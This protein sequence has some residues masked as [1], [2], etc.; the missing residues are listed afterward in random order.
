M[1]LRGAAFASPTNGVNVDNWLSTIKQQVVAQARAASSGQS[2]WLAAFTSPMTITGS[3]D[4]FDEYTSEALFNGQVTLEFST[5]GKILV[6]GQLN[7]AANNISIS[8]RL[9]ADLSKIS[10][11]AAT[12]LF[13][14]DVPD[15]VRVL[16][17]Y[18]KLQMGFKNAQGD[19]VAFTV[20]S[21]SPTSPTATLEGPGN[22]GTVAAG[23]LNGRGFVDVSY[24]VPSGD[25]LDASSITD[26][27]PEFTVT[28]TTG[29]IQ[30]DSTQAPILVNATT[31][32]YRY[33]TVSSN[34]GRDDHADP[35]RQRLGASSR[36]RAATR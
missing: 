12:V 1:Q 11:G 2:S 25:R 15:Q 20:P 36:P 24:A 7:F 8:G 13:L 35:D 34:V 5:D 21:D 18:G 22:G 26:L 17:L 19:A 14:A 6:I 10:Q 31:N 3:A 23:D 29:S 32:T 4:I 30:L 16:S 33:W 27:A 9:Y 28:S